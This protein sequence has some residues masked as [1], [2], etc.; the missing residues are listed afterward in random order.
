[1]KSRNWVNTYAARITKMIADIEDQHHR[2]SDAMNNPPLP[3]RF[4][5]K[6]SVSICP[7]TKLNIRVK[8]KI[9]TMKMEILLEAYIKQLLGRIHLRMGDG[10]GSYSN[11][12]VKCTIATSGSLLERCRAPRK[13]DRRM[14]ESYRKDPMVDEPAPSIDGI[15]WIG[16]IMAM[17]EEKPAVE[18]DDVAPIEFALMAMSSSSLDNEVY[19][20]SYCSK[21]CRKISENLNT[22]ISKIIEELSD[23]ETDMYNYKRGLSQVEARK[24]LSWTGLPE[25]VDD[26]VTDYTRSTP[27]VDVSN[28]VRSEQGESSS[29]SIGKKPIVNISQSSNVMPNNSSATIIKGIGILKLKWLCSR[30]MNGNISYFL[31]MSL[32]DGGYVFHLDMEVERLLNNLVRGLPSKSFENDHSCVDCLKGKQHKASCKTKLL[33]DDD[34]SRC[35]NGG[36]FKNR[37]MDEFYT[38]KGIK[39]EL[40]NARTPQQNG[41]AK[42]RNRTLIEAARTMV[43]V[44]KSYNKTPYELF[45]GRTPAIGFLKLFGCH[46]MIL[47]TLDH[48]GK[49]D[50]KGDEGYFVGYSL[51]SKAFRVF[52]K[53]TKKVEENLHVDFL[54]NKPIEKVEEK[55]A[56]PN[57]NI[58]T[59]I[60][61]HME[62][63]NDSMRN[64][65]AKDY[66]PKEQDRNADVPE[67]SGNT[68]PT[69]TIKDPSADQVEMSSM[70]EDIQ[71]AGSDTRPPMLDRT[72]FES[73]QQRIRLYCLGKDNGENIMKSIKEGP[74]HMR[75]VSDVITGEKFNKV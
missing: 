71:C 32:M 17:E 33:W 47:N 22:K 62:T 30:H 51:S 9:I 70:Q 11:R 28:C 37:E 54:E 48:L 44:N 64:S 7:E 3:L 66:T 40:S 63:S 29:N 12:N 55:G 18:A 27:S 5:Q 59:D 31:S 65:E 35:D 60:S 26:T 72:D 6:F 42:R 38:K 21:S 69:A 46:V 58:S 57:W 20:D 4:S 45:N 8:L 53:R 13:S 68:N 50:A 67:S 43:L 61:A 41:V 39:R 49:F 52:N 1:M 25:F 23:C 2:P 56:G 34:F 16:A 10:N 24:D 15:G 14:R 73:W 74:F 75:T 36:E 19:D